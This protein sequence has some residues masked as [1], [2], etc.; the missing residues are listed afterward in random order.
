MAGKSRKPSFDI[1]PLTH[2]QQ[3]ALAESEKQRRINAANDFMNGKQWPGKA[4][5]DR[6]TAAEKA[7]Y[8]AWLD[9]LD[10]L[11]AIDTS[12]APDIDWPAACL[13]RWRRW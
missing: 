12:N 11:D 10:A 1:P 6:L 8:N 7:Q 13:V 9:Y 2:E 4:A 5:M 3:V